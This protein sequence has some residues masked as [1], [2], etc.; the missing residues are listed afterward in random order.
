M[1]EGGG[2]HVVAIN[3]QAVAYVDLAIRIGLL[4]SMVRRQNGSSV[5]GNCEC[6]SVWHSL[7]LGLHDGLEVIV[8][9][10]GSENAWVG[11]ADRG[12]V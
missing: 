7:P 8:H 2:V 1:E 12:G 4:V 6:R 11:D 5:L 10:S 9:G 3:G